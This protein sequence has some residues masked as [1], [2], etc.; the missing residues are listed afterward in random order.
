M[1]FI[2][3]LVLGVGVVVMAMWLRDQHIM[4]RWYEYLI[5]GVGLVLLIW[6][7]HDFFASL[8]EHNEIAAWTFL[9]LLGVPGLILLVVSFL[10]P[11][12][13]HRQ[14]IQ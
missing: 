13:R 10:L 8:A 3:G 14:T 1:W 6:T 2:F 4:V 7:I 9:W 12:R 5:G 11:W